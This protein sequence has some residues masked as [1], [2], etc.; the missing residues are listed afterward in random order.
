MRT[1]DEVIFYSMEWLKSTWGQ[2]LDM[3]DIQR[4]LQTYFLYI[5]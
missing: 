5:Y 2:P 3:E 4:M 1:R